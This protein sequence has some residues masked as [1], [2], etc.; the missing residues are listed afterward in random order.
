MQELEKRIALL[1][2]LI[3]DLGNKKTQ[4][5]EM[6]EQYRVQLSRIVEFVVYREGDPSNALSLMS[7]VQG[8]L[9]EVMQT[10]AH[11]NMMAEK[12]STELEALLLTKR[13]AE[14]RSQLSQ[15]EE[16][17]KELS[18]RLSHMSGE[19]RGR[20]SARAAPTMDDFRA[21]NEEV[22]NVSQEISRLHNLIT[23]ASE[24]AARTVHASPTS[25]SQGEE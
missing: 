25:R 21:I 22:A 18:S 20:R 16:R 3:A 10:S 15:L 11:L 2:L 5:A 7:E 23:E 12:A 14:A 19:E 6:E 24:R 4:L 17:Q 9:D 8:K 13:V 1:R